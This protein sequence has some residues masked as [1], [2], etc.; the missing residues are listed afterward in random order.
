MSSPLL[1]DRE[2]PE[3]SG[4]GDAAVP[5]TTWRRCGPSIRSRMRGPGWSSPTIR[6]S[7]GDDH[8]R[9]IGAPTL[10][11]GNQSFMKIY[12]TELLFQ[13]QVGAPIER[14]WIVRRSCNGD[15]RRTPSPARAC[16]SDARAHSAGQV[17]RTA[18]SPVQSF[19]G[20]RDRVKV[21]KTWQ[22]AQK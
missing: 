3:N 22:S 19:S 1:L 6:Y 5:Q 7:F 15:S 2:F 21:A 13:P 11:L 18:A 17:V 12:E 20:I 8:A 14:A 10:R 16:G 9:S 4:T